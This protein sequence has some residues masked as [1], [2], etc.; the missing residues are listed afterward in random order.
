MKSGKLWM[1]AV[2]GALVLAGCNEEKAPGEEAEVPPSDGFLPARA[3]DF[4]PN[5]KE[6]QFE[7]RILGV[8][9]HSYE[10]AFVNVDSMTVSAGGQLLPV[11][12]K[13]T[14]MDLA[15]RDHAGLV[16]YFTLP[17]GVDSAQ[18]V[19]RFDEYGAFEDGSRMGSLDVRTVPVRFEVT[20]AL[21]APRKHAVVHV[22]LARSLVSPRKGDMLVLPMTAVAF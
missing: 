3:D 14:V 11:E 10:S 6:N 2:A 19:V 15:R 16:G 20:R 5:D 8:G 12:M 17:P 4:Q 1:A 13:A 9:N 22:D 21:L 18:V 7:V